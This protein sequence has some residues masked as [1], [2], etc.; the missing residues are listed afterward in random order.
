MNN[1]LIVIIF[2]VFLLIVLVSSLQSISH[3]QKNIQKTTS[4]SIT[5]IQNLPL[6]TPTLT[7]TPIPSQ[8]QIPIQRPGYRVNV[9]GEGG[10]D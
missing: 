9:G 1:K 10:D 8:V 7:L 3:P 5:K 2:V 6:A 4:S